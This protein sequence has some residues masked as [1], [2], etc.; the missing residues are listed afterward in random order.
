LKVRKLCWGY[1]DAVEGVSGIRNPDAS[2]HNHSAESDDSV[3]LAAHNYEAVDPSNCEGGGVHLDGF[4]MNYLQLPYEFL[5]VPRT[6]P[7]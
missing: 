1:H 7:S 2:V 6:S 3:G 4:F 5:T